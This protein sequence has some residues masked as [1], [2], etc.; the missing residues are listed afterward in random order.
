MKKTLL[1]SAIAIFTS[2][3]H[4]QVTNGLVAKYSFNNGNANDDVGTNHG[5]VYGASLTTDRFGN[6]NKAYEFDGISNFIELGSSSTLKPAIGSVSLWAKLIEAS[7]NGWGYAYN[8][9]FLSMNGNSSSFF[10]AVGI[11]Y[12]LNKSNVLAITTNPSNN[13]ERYGNSSSNMTAG[14]WIHIVVTYDNDSL[15]LYMNGS[16]EFKIEKGFT[17]VFD[18]TFPVIIGKSDDELNKRY[19]HGAI[20]DIRIYNRILSANEVNSLFNEPNPLTLE[21]KNLFTNTNA[22]GIFPNPTK[23]QINFSNSTNVIMTNVSGQVIVDKKNI[24]SLDLSN[25]PTG[26]Y[27][28]TFTNHNGQVIQRSKIL[29]E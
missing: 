6:A 16:L 29:K 14:E 17:S 4:G 18:S 8:P 15:A 28:L 21:V 25:Q 22:I 2:I 24:S 10:E 5:T 23:N 27:F 19:F 11:Y 3:A 13:L 12:S 9:I 1:I 20:D 26:I 7:Y